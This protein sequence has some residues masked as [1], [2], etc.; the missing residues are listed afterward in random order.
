MLSTCILSTGQSTTSVNQST[1]QA[2]RRDT[3]NETNKFDA[4]LA[5]TGM[6]DEED[7]RAFPRLSGVD[8]TSGLLEGVVIVHER[9]K[10]CGG[11]LGV[12]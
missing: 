6:L 10:L 3:Q 2:T 7:L 11:S 9:H 5:Q 4:C 1:N 8:V 12:Q